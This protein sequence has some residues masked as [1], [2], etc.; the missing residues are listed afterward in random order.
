MGAQQNKTKKYNT[1]QLVYRRTEH[2]LYGSICK[3][4]Y[5]GQ[6][7]V[8]TSPFIIS[9]SEPHGEETVYG[10]VALTLK[11]ISSQ[12]DRLRE[13]NARTSERLR[14]AGVGQQTGRSVALPKSEI[15]E[16]IMNEQER[17][18]EE[19]L[20]MVSVNLRR[21]SEIFPKGKFKNN[22]I[23]VYDYEDNKVANI[24]LTE[25]ANLLLHNRYIAINGQ[26]VTDLF[27]DLKFMSGLPKMGFKFD[28]IEYVDEVKNMI[29]GITVGDLAKKLQQE[30]G[31]LSTQS[32]MKDI[33]FVFQNLYSFGRAIID[34]DGPLMHIMKD[35]ATRYTKSRR[36]KSGGM[37]VALA[38]TEPKVYLNPDL[39]KKQI[40]IDV[41]VNDKKET[42]NM[43]YN[44]FFREV[45]KALGDKQLASSLV[46]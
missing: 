43:A 9:K 24:E 2:F 46:S 17:L 38:F 41:T 6:D 5:E 31:K 45:I 21:L 8:W 20:T 19:V 44:T 35:V 27:S 23:A 36:P 4:E 39:N 14:A 22:Q 26:Y 12:M 33:L 7:L 3:I 37:K 32:G 25:I 30:I 40:R 28:F 29:D 15:G 16:E 1:V 11:R 42:I 13:F 10:T 18:F 34:K